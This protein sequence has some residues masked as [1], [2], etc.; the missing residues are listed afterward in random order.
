[1]TPEEE[2]KEKMNERNTLKT[3]SGN[4]R[5][6]TPIEDL[7]LI[8]DALEIAQSYASEMCKRQRE[9]CVIAHRFAVIDMFPEEQWE[10]LSNINKRIGSS[11]LATEEVSN[12]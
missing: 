11:P 1:M 9:I 6:I 2:L 5:T 12:D 8:S 4:S 10:V 7:I 3:G